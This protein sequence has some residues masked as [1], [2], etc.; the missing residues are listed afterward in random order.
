[1]S[2]FAR[3]LA[4]C[5]AVLCL[6]RGA[7]AETVTV[8][9][10]DGRAFTG[11]VHE[12]TEFKI[13]LNVPFSGLTSRMTFAK[14]DIESIVREEAAAPTDDDFEDDADDSTDDDLDNDTENDDSADAPRD[15]GY[16]VLPAYGGIG[17]ELTAGY[18]EA[19]LA[20]AVRSGAE[21][22]IIHLESPGGLVSEL[23]A[24]RDTLDE[25]EDR[26]KIA[27]FVDREAFSAAALLCLSA[28]HLY[29]GDRATIGAAV[30]FSG[31][32]GNYKV[33]AKFNSAFAAKWRVLA[34]RAGRPGLLI[35]AMI[36][37]ETEVYADK[38]AEPWRLAPE[39]P[40]GDEGKAWEIVDSKRAILSLT[41][42][43]A[44]ATD[45]ADG[46]ASSPGAVAPN[47]NLEICQPGSFD[48]DRFSRSYF[49]EQARNINL[50]TA[51]LKNFQKD[52][53]EVKKA[54]NKRQFRARLE[55]LDRHLGQIARL[56]NKH[57]YVRNLLRLE[58][59]T[60][61]GIRESQEYIRQV[62]K[63]L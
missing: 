53:D 6:A 43:D 3:L 52:L 32:V 61:E 42:T 22:I 38:S 13:V 39:R 41:T 16:V 30:A 11:S 56:Y 10:R 51:T 59:A 17:V 40:R 48:G 29:V 57:D 54:Q 15:G 55:E 4:C 33:D 37:P 8:T 34:E 46:L 62:L 12:E 18:F 63:N 25:Y 45:A 19:A 20:R 9:L 1:M 26:I 31:G 7:S 5:F 49:G 58:G 35:D 21:A 36:L 2:S 60:I 47:L 44:L 24:I 23:D 14:R 50:V 28:E 27:F